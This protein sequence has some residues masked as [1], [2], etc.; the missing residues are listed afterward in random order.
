[1]RM[2]AVV[3]GIA[4]ILGGCQPVVDDG[5][6]IDGE[7]EQDVVERALEADVVEILPEYEPWSLDIDSATLSRVA[8][9]KV[10]QY[11]DEKNAIVPPVAVTVYI[12]P[13]IPSD[14]HD[15]FQRLAESAVTPLVGYVPEEVF[16]VLGTNGAF[17]EDIVIANGLVMPIDSVT[18]EPC[19]KNLGGCNAGNILWMGGGTRLSSYDGT[20]SEFPV[21]L[22]H[23]LVHLMQDHLFPDLG[24]QIPPRWSENFQPVWFIEGAADFYAYALLDVAGFFEY[25]RNGPWAVD[26]WEVEE[27]SGRGDP[28]IQG[29]F[30]VEFFVAS[31][32]FGAVLELHQLLSNGVGFEDAFLQI[33]GISLEEFYDLAES[34][35]LRPAHHR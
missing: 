4:L 22:V 31:L 8:V 25:K 26:L 12:D 5:A 10:A 19:K 32:G 16:V 11:V 21:N 9:M 17:L 30:A 18:R 13:E 1:M 15:Y 35:D 28:Y 14:R 34:F 3:V 24:G 27:W 2:S 33:A 7:V 29:Q 20:A 6:L 23:Q